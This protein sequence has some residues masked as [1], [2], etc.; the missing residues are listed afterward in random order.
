[1]VFPPSQWKLCFIKFVEDETIIN[2]TS[3]ACSDGW[4]SL[5]AAGYL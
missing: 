5:K 3:T 2:R 4:F 1:M